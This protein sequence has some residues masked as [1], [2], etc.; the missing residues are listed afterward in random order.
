MI[1][2]EEHVDVMAEP[3]ELLHIV[4]DLMTRGHYFPD[5]VIGMRELAARPPSPTEKFLPGQRA[6]FVSE[7]ESR[8]HEISRVE[9]WDMAEAQIEERRLR[10]SKN[11]VFTWRLSELTLG[12]LRVTVTFSADFAGLEKITKGKA[13]KAFVSTMLHRLKQYVE[14]KRSFSGPRTFVTQSV[15]ADPLDMP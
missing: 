15:P 14:D 1:K 8:E 10:S 2:F 4:G 9:E 7:G 12:T 6:A 3:E 11:E 13:A 5:G